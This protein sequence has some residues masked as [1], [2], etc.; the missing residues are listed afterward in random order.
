MKNHNLI[1]IFINTI[2]NGQSYYKGLIIDY[3]LCYN[4]YVKKEK[5]QE[6]LLKSRNPIST[7]NAQEW[8]SNGNVQK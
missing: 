8:F 6:T 3:D 2:N 1:K 5:I 4:R 7:L